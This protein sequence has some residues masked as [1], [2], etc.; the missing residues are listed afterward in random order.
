MYIKELQTTPRLALPNSQR[1]RSIGLPEH[2]TATLQ[3][4]HHRQAM[5]LRLS[6]PLPDNHGECYTRE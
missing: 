5:S 2:A 1:I 3:L 6:V 4:I